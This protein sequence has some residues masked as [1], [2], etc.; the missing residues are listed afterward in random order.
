[1]SEKSFVRSRSFSNEKSPSRVSVFSVKRYARINSPGIYVTHLLHAHKRPQFRQRDIIPL[2]LANLRSSDRPMIMANHLRR[3][4]FPFP[5]RQPPSP[6]QRHQQT[7]I[8]ISME[9][10]DI[11]PNHMLHFIKRTALTGR[12]V[13][14]Q[15][16]QPHIDPIAVYYSL[17][18]RSS[19]S[20]GNGPRN[21]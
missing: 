1:M 3:Q 20:D 14:R 15:R 5:S 11:F 10:H 7:R 13:V 12:Q 2:A 4:R 8:I 9:L 16:V 21:T 18:P 17:S 19:T 6:T